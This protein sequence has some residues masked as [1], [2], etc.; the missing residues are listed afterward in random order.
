MSDPSP[1]DT[2]RIDATIPNEIKRAVS[3]VDSE[4]R[5]KILELLLT[6]KELSYTELVE[7]LGIKK[8]SATFHLSKLKK[9]SILQNYSKENFESPY[10]SYYSISPYGR[11][12]TQSLL[13]SLEPPPPPKEVFFPVTASQFEF[14]HILP[15]SY[16][17][18]PIDIAF[19]S[20]I[21]VPAN[22]N[23]LPKRKTVPKQLVI[24]QTSANETMA[25]LLVAQ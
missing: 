15:A 10:D 16:R 5:W 6:N 22:P 4:I 25:P 8:G 24:S 3:S 14:E 2:T 23:V 13:K 17:S 11:R 12:F 7:K 20:A 21:T 9:G 18:T 19:L 1:D